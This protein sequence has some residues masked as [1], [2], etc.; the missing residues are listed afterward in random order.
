LTEYGVQVG[1]DVVIA[2]DPKTF[3]RSAA[4]IFIQSFG[5]HDITKPLKG[6]RVLIDY[7]RS[8]TPIQGT[9]PRYRV[10]KLLETTPDAYG[11]TNVEALY[12]TQ[13]AFKDQAD[14]A[15]P[16]S[17]GVAVEEVDNKPAEEAAAPTRARKFMRMVVVGDADIFA[18]N[19]ADQL[20]PNL[21]FCRNAVNWLVER[22]DLVTIESRPEM[23][24]VLVV[25]DST[26]KVVFWLL[27]VALPL[28]VL[29]LGSVVWALRSYGSRAK[30]HRLP[31]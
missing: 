2:T 11:E 20:P 5:S 24:R 29:L 4:T 28:V 9:P 25:D 18:N 3:Y 30:Q 23:Q 26:G 13:Q 31:S 17:V 8:I 10:T 12:K 21:D 14:P 6:F 19:L 1:N 22:K 27:V 7:A 16:V 15:G